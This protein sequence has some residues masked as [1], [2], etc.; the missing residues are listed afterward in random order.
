MIFGAQVYYTSARPDKRSS[1]IFFFFH[2]HCST[3]TLPT[4]T[5]FFQ[6]NN[7]SLFKKKKMGGNGFR[8]WFFLIHILIKS[9]KMY[10]IHAKG[11][12]TTKVGLPLFRKPDLYD[13]TNIILDKRK[14]NELLRCFYGVPIL[15]T[16]HRG[17]FFIRKY[18][19][20]FNQNRFT[21]F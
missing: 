7:G 10:C 14:R 21:S 2:F 19:E 8:F 12:A 16:P 1:L 13:V 20:R 6:P 17:R 15:N 3:K 9:S 18:S 5:H 4:A 11:E